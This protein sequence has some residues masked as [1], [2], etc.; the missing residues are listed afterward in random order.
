MPDY[1]DYCGFTIELSISESPTTWHM[2]T[3][4]GA[5][6]GDDFVLNP[7]FASLNRTF[8]RTDGAINCGFEM[9]SLAKQQIDEFI[10]QRPA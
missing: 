2:E 6:K 8:H 9:K 10:K 5:F 3:K 4:V 1:E 7:K